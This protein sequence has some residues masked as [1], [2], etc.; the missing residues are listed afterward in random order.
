MST[1]I[2]E[3]G[4]EVAVTCVLLVAGAAIAYWIDFGFTRMTNQISWVGIISFYIESQV[5]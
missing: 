4:P 2:G 5:C 3:R 1:E